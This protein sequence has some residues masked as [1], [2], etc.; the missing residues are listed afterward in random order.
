MARSATK[1][2]AVATPETAR[3]PA[4]PFAIG[5]DDW[6][7]RGATTD[8]AALQALARSAWPPCLAVT[9][10]D[11]PKLAEGTA[12]A[13]VGQPHAQLRGVPSFL[14]VAKAIEFASQ[15]VAASIQQDRRSRPR[16]LITLVVT[17]LLVVVP[18]ILS[19]G[20]PTYSITGT[21]R[22]G[23]QAAAAVKKNREDKDLA[24]AFCLDAT[25]EVNEI[26]SD[27]GNASSD[28]TRLRAVKE[29]IA[30]YRTNFASRGNALEKSGLSPENLDSLADCV[31]NQVLPPL[32]TATSSTNEAI[33]QL[34]EAAASEAAL[35]AQ[36]ETLAQAEAAKAE[37]RR[38]RRLRAA[39]EQVQPMAQDSQPA[40]ALDP[41]IQRAAEEPGAVRPSTPSFREKLK[42]AIDSE[43]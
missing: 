18:A 19:F 15:E 34:E 3:E 38:R 26:A 17:A 40:G 20:A 25:R 36:V 8:I 6:L 30:S 33:R 31:A 16:V 12:A 29:R 24:A 21:I 10:V 4:T 11:W 2:P 14:T 22:M 42:S 32:E 27:I 35:Q 9:A 43:L 5:F 7:V 28:L 39:Q 41:R 23:E 37:A 1:S 13:G